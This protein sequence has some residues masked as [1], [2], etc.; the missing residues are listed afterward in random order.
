M[1]FPA[2][3]HRRHLH[4]G[5][6]DAGLV[7][8]AERGKKPGIAPKARVGPRLGY[9]AQLRPVEPSPA[10]AV[11]PHGGPRPVTIICLSTLWS[12]RQLPHR[13]AVGVRHS[14]G[15]SEPGPWRKADVG[16][17]LHTGKEGGRGRNVLTEAERELCRGVG[18]WGQKQE[19]EKEK[20]RRQRHR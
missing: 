15:G 7:R 19:G 20:E 10:D 1:A 9:L 17:S 18:G 11:R 5:I 3:F 8:G 14:D 2:D 13:C 12:K 4:L 6:K 16:G